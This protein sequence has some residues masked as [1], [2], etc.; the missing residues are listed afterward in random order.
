MVKLNWQ[1]NMLSMHRMVFLILC[2][3]ISVSSLGQSL[4]AHKTYSGQFGN[5]STGKATYSYISDENGERLFDGPFKYSDGATTYTGTFTKNR[6]TGRWVDTWVN[7]LRGPKA[8]LKTVTTLNFNDK[9]LLDGAFLI[10]DHYR[11]GKVVN[12]VKANFKNGF[13]D[14]PF[15]ANDYS[16][17]KSGHKITGQFDV[18]MRIGKWT[19]SYKNGYVDYDQWNDYSPLVRTVNEST[20]DITEE[21]NLDS[22]WFRVDWKIDKFLINHPYRD[23]DLQM[24][25]SRILTLYLSDEIKIPENFSVSATFEEESGRMDA[26]GNI[27]YRVEIRVPEREDNTDTRKTIKKNWGEWEDFLLDN[28]EL[29]DALS[30]DPRSEVRFRLLIGPEGELSFVDERNNNDCLKLETLKMLRGLQWEVKGS[31]KRHPIAI[32]PVK[33]N[34]NVKRLQSIK[35][36]IKKQE[37]EEAYRQSEDYIHER[38]DEAPIFPGGDKAMINFITKNIVLPKSYLSA[39]YSGKVWIRFVVWKDGSVK[40]PKILRGLHPD[41]DKEVQRVVSEFPSFVPAKINGKP[42]N[43]YYEIRIPFKLTE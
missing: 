35:E 33:V 43:V 12:V 23:S 26:G 5:Y 28:P 18:G 1:Y 20:G 7:T 36:E 37:Q 2:L 9:G 41:L 19:D 25:D 40:E 14:G 24:R 17:N 21:Y 29:M 34:Y 10:Q 11:S 22:D 8:R 6:Q 4:D 31:R 27:S 39:G 13:I 42:V 3:M 38:A 16:I 30:E 32:C 15:E